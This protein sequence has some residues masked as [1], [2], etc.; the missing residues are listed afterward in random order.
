MLFTACEKDYNYIAPAVQLPQDVQ[1]SFKD[2]IQPIFNAGGCTA[3]TCHGGANEPTLTPDQSYISV[4]DFV[5]V[6][7]PETS[8]LYTD[9]NTGKMPEAPSPKLS[10]TDIAKILLWIKQGAKNN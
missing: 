3:A 1:V 6:S 8:V 4:I 2:E 5:N 7:N 9:V 10:D